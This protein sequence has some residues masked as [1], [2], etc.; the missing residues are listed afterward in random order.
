MEACI[1]FLTRYIR[2]R[3]S[4]TN[5]QCAVRSKHLRI[6]SF[7]WIWVPWIQKSPFFFYA[8]ALFSSEYTCCKVTCRTEEKSSVHETWLKI[9]IFH[10]IQLDI[11]NEFVCYEDDR[12]PGGGS[13]QEDASAGCILLLQ[14]LDQQQQNFHSVVLLKRKI[15]ILIRVDLTYPFFIILNRNLPEWPLT[16]CCCPTTLPC[17]SWSR[18]WSSRESGTSTCSRR[19]REYSYS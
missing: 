7:A 16:L 10:L 3:V 5:T 15:R 6:I 18:M 12:W 9:Y 8:S 17:S 13:L 2:T 14:V 19:V 4:W 1:V 11:E